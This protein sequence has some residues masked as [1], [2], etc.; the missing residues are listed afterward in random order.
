[1]C[2]HPIIA[3]STVNAMGRTVL[4]TKNVIETKGYT[5]AHS[6]LTRIDTHVG[7]DCPLTLRLL[8]SGLR[9]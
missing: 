9:V 5:Q 8:R 1:M 4:T 6:A 2:S 3:F 7:K